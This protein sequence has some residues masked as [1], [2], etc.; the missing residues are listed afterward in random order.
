LILQYQFQL[1]EVLEMM[2]EMQMS[3][4]LIRLGCE[5]SPKDF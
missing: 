4:R 2:L 5:L 3:R 1:Q